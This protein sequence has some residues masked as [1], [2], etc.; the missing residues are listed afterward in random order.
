MFTLAELKTI[1]KLKS[2]PATNVQSL[3]D[4]FVSQEV[5]LEQMHRACLFNAMVYHET[6]GL[7][8]N[9]EIWGPTAAQKRYEGRKDLGNTQKGD[10]SKYRGYGMAQLTGR[11]NVT[12]FWK[13]CVKKGLN[14]PDFVKSPQLIATGIWS[15]LSAIWFWDEGNQ[16][17]KSLNVYADENNIEMITRIWNG[18]LN[19][20]EDR[21]DYYD[22]SALVA[23]GYGPTDIIGFQRDAKNSG[24]KLGTSGKNKD[25][26]DGQS[27]PRTRALLHKNLLRLTNKKEL[28]NK[29]AAAPV[30]VETLQAV[31]VKTPSTKTPWYLSKEFLAPAI[32]GGGLTGGATMMEKFGSIPWQNL[33][34]I[35]LLGF[36]VLTAVLM[37]QRYRDHQKQEVIAQAIEA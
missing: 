37:I 16:T 27:G 1:S 35:G 4:A 31:A 22:R 21:L 7:K 18:G 23:L 6:G 15:G 34:V 9:K 19:G 2:P 28:S 32:T 24:E 8:W 20:Y 30:V 25:G 5:G 13:W 36:G 33:L 11:G 12:K 29:V 17:G 26:V 14:P 10:G 3:F